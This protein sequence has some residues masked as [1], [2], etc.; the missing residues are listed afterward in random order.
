MK[1][2]NLCLALLMAV[3]PLVLEANS[4][5]QASTPSG[6]AF[7]NAC[8]GS[9]AFGG[10][11]WPGDAFNNGA[12]DSYVNCNYAASSVGGSATVNASNSGSYF[13]YGFSNSASA[14]ASPGAL[15]LGGNNDASSPTEFSGSAANVGYNDTVT[16]SG[17]TGTGIWVVPFYI[18]G[19]L[20]STGAGSGSSLWMTAYKNNTQIDAYGANTA[21]YNLFNSIN[22]THNGDIGSSWDREAIAWGTSGS[23]L[24]SMTIGQFV[25]F[26]IPITFGTSFEYGIYAEIWNTQSSGGYSGPTVES[27]DFNHTIAYAAGSYVVQGSTIIGNLTITSSASSGI[28]YS[29]SLV[30]IPE[31]G[32][33]CLVLLGAAALAVRRRK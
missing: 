6:A 31:P 20:S 1:R 30:T 29:E 3:S 33:I 5:G 23:G 9:Q 25:Y 27:A 11:P 32:T 22:T 10:I 24:T 16:I 8:A 15:H 2:S 21:A 28:N 19:T 26:A 17:G 4:V 7:V 13:G 18:D 14:S 12:T